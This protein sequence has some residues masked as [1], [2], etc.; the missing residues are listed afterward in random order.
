M[1]SWKFPWCVVLWMFFLFFPFLVARSLWV[2]WFLFPPPS[3]AQ[4]P[5]KKKKFQQ[6]QQ[7]KTPGDL[8]YL[9]T[10]WPNFITDSLANESDATMRTHL[11]RLYNS[12]AVHEYFLFYFF[13]LLFPNNWWLLKYCFKYVL[14]FIENN[15]I[16][17]SWCSG[18]STPASVY[19][20]NQGRWGGQ[21]WTW[22]WRERNL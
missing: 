9:N 3:L 17:S 1:V 10:L 4:T 16:F 15:I 8:T 11:R 13:L 2:F 21:W 19:V 22:P 20:G 14:T 18:T 12:E 7:K 5:Q 6:Q